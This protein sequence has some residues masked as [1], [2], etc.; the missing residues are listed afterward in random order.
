MKILFFIVIVTL[1]SFTADAQVKHTDFASEPFYINAAGEKI[2]LEK[3][4]AKMNQARKGNNSPTYII[5]AEHASVSFP[6][7]DTIKL[8]VNTTQDLSMIGPSRIFHIYHLNINNGKREA[9][10]Q[11][12]AGYGK[13]SGNERI[14]YQHKAST[15]KIVFIITEKLPPGEYAFFNMM[16]AKASDYSIYAFCFRIK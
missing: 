9:V 5:E 6:I 3:S 11:V 7:T 13:K 2:P 4:A 10:V 14:D 8:L 16:T 12:D 1:R 15:D